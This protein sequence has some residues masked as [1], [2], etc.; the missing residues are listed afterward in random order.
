MK[1]ASSP[2][3]KISLRQTFT[4]L[5]Y[6][7]YRLWFYGQMVSLFGTWMQSTAQG[8]LIYQLTDSPLY[9]GLVA[10]ASGFAT[11]ALMLFAGV[12]A[13]RVPRRT[14]LVIT[15]TVM[16]LLA[17]V[18]A[19]LTFL[20]WVQVWH[21]VL[22]AFLLGIAS[23]FDAPA[24]QAFVLEMVERED[25]TNAIAL[26]ATMF[27]T[28]VAIGPAA[29]GFAYAAFGPAWCFTLNGISF[30]AVIAALLRMRLKPFSTT[31]R[32]STVL[33]DLREGMGYV[34]R[35]P[36]IRTLTAMAGVGSLFAIS[37]NTLIPAWAVSILHGDATTNGLL[38]SARGLG[39]LASALVV[40]SLGRFK[41]KGRVLTLG[42]FA[43]PGML[44]AFS[45]VRWLPLSLLTLMGAGAAQVLMMNLANA[46][47]Q[48]QSPDHLRGRVMGV[49]SWV[50][51]GM[52]PLG[53]L[54]MG[55]L[56][57]RIHE[58]LSIALGAA[59]AMAFAG[60]VWLFEPKVR[61]LE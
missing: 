45:S 27:N 42:S 33:G 29:A 28:A 30:I 9:L 48:T 56:A 25:L 2:A 44:L 12:V 37:A 6:P 15:Q 41:F 24:R 22:L 43:F 21:I 38:Q 35:H 36:I 58:P 4:A 49:Y 3:G 26:N 7:N 31:A 52:M 34:G 23:A 51:F 10:G 40:A 11:W 54:L 18:L 8:F 32:R 19:A 59:L 57:E 47:V 20:H 46:L 14:V 60:M 16:M 50:F 53:G 39:A 55:A 17:F 13:D 61:A 5:K 1:T